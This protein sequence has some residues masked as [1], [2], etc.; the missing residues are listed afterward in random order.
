MTHASA[1]ASS[2]TNPSSRAAKRGVNCSFR[3]TAAD[4]PSCRRP[5][6]RALAQPMVSPSGFLWHRI[7]MS[8]VPSRRETTV[9]RSTF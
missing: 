2:H 6:H 1:G 8:S 7:R 3:S 9:S 5:R 4:F